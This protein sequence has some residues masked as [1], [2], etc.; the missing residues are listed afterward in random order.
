MII[1]RIFLGIGLAVFVVAL[2]MHG[3]RLLRALRDWRGLW[4]VAFAWIAAALSHTRLIGQEETAATG[5][6][7]GMGDLLQIGFLG[8]TFLWTLVLALR[9]PRAAATGRLPL[10]AFGVYAFLGVATAFMGPKPLLSIYKASQI[11][12]FVLLAWVT[13]AYLRRAGRPRFLPELI[14]SMLTLIML[15]AALGGIFAADGA[16]RTLYTGGGG[17]FG[18]TLYG[19]FPHVHPNT[20]GLLAAI[21]VLVG[22]GRAINAKLV[23]YK[24]F[25][26]ALALLAFSVMFAAQ[27]RTAVVALVLGFVALSFAVHRVRP[28]LWV[29][30]LGG[31]A[32]GFNYLLSGTTTG[33]EEDV[34]AYLKRGQTDQQLESMSG[35]TGL[36]EIGIAM[37]ADR[38]LLGHGFQAG[39]RFSS[40]S[41]GLAAGSN[42]HNGHMQVLVDSGVI[43]YLIWLAFSG[44]IAWRCGVLLLRA[45]PGDTEPKQFVA[46]IA[47]IGLMIFLRTSVGHVLVS[48]DFNTMLY[49]A[50]LVS[51]CVGPD[52]PI[53]RPV[54]PTPTRPQGG[55]LLRTR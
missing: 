38:P 42:M 15:S 8:L 26:S 7:V 37:L 21:M 33:L 11:L 30:A 18:V 6:G 12:V 43:G 39:A 9:A 28:I 50:L 4:G 3:P 17:L 5:A 24:S 48:M 31:L 41:Y 32:L 16:Y 19:V 27:S 46:E 29:I 40:P 44:V 35:R 34:L 20:L 54:P 10:I 51:M 2:F 23:G 45:R 55:R 49:V 1:L 36:W 52:R 22:V 13:I 25:Y 14:Y 47:A 53:D